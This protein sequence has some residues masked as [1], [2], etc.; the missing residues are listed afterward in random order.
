[1]Q[2][3]SADWVDS[4]GEKKSQVPTILIVEGT[5]FSLEPN[6]FFVS[7]PGFRP[8]TSLLPSR[9]SGPG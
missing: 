3:S 4:R 8:S 9:V 5:I 7:C 6:F 2:R 1:M